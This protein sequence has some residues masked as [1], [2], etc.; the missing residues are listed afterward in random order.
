MAK[1]NARKAHLVKAVHY[2]RKMRKYSKGIAKRE[3]ETVR[4]MAKDL[5]D[6]PWGGGLVGHP[7]SFRL[8]MQIKQAYIREEEAD[9]HMHQHT[10]NA[11]V[12]ELL[13]AYH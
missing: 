12:I 11:A 10:L 1:S 6:Q 8:G 7:A 4:S 9:V 13:N 5:H 3:K 2:N